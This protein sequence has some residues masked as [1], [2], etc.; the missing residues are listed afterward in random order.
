MFNRKT[1]RNERGN[2]V[3]WLLLVVVIIL[4]VVGAS[5]GA[6]T[7]SVPEAV[8]GI[9]FLSQY[10]DPEAEEE[11][12]A[13]PV[14]VSEEDRLSQMVI[15]FRNQ[16]D[17]AEN[18]VTSLEEQLAAEQTLVQE[19]EDEIARLQDVLNLSRDENISNVALIY[20]EMGSDEAAMILSNLGADRASLILNEMDESSAADILAAMEETLATQ[21]TQ[22]L[23]GFEGETVVNPLVPPG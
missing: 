16:R 18:R 3:G 4:V 22:I 15:D 14:S 12:G 11:E 1:M 23:A 17:V 7:F 6:I 21:I 5:M 20:E 13:T 19:R 10:L 8:A 2:I 9:P